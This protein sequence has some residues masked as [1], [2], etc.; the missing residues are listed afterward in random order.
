MRHTLLVATLA[1]TW[2][3]LPAEAGK[4]EIPNDQAIVISG[5]LDPGDDAQFLSS[6]SRLRR[7]GTIEVHLSSPGGSVLAAMKIAD[8][9]HRAGLAAQIPYRATCASACVLVFAAGVTR[10]ADADLTIAVHSV[11][12]PGQADADQKLIENGGTLAGDNPQGPRSA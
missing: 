7:D 2:L 8:I 4:F 10:I 3:A 9:V 11:G 5:R 6:H 12:M 1:T